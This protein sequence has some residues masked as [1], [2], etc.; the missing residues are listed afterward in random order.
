MNIIY[1]RQLQV[2]P[3]SRG[4]EVGVES[5]SLRTGKDR[6]CNEEI[7]NEGARNPLSSMAH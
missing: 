4:S 5:D 7:G 1:Y 3:V 6:E 2:E